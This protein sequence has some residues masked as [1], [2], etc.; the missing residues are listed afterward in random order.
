MVAKRLDQIDRRLNRMERDIGISVETTEYRF[1]EADTALAD[2]AADR[3]DG[4]AVLR[5]PSAR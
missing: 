2:L 1:D 5:M 4:A 3:V